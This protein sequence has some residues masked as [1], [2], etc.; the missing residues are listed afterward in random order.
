MAV[1]YEIAVVVMSGP[2]EV[3]HRKRHGPQLVGQ[4]EIHLL[5]A[6]VAEID[7]P[8]CR[9]REVSGRHGQRGLQG[10]ARLLD[11]APVIRAY[12]IGT[13]AERYPFVLSGDVIRSKHGCRSQ[14]SE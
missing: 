3:G 6:A 13:A 8:P 2:V 14:Y 4:R 1:E 11:A 5:V 9:Y 7:R 10:R 12:E